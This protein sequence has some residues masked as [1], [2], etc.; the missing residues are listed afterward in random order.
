MTC[1]AVRTNWAS[2]RRYEATH[3]CKGDGFDGFVLAHEN[4]ADAVL[5]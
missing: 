3:D 4:V 5:S 1:P 2:H